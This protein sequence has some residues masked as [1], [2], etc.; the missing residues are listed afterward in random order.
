MKLIH[1]LVIALLAA[2]AVCANTIQI[3]NTGVDNYFSLGA[4]GPTRFPFHMVYEPDAAK[5]MTNLR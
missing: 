4:P 2:T 5:A 1:A 3:Y